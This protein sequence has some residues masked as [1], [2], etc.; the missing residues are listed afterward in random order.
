MIALSPQCSDVTFQSIYV[1]INVLSLLDL[2]SY[3]GINAGDF[4][5][6][7]ERRFWYSNH[8]RIAGFLKLGIQ[9]KF[10]QR[11]LIE[12]YDVLCCWFVQDDTECFLS[13]KWFFCLFAVFLPR[14]FTVAMCH[15]LEIAFL[16]IPMISMVS[17]TVTLVSWYGFI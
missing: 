6:S 7:D 5:Y 9:F 14:N 17:E 3:H 11:S 8:E 4:L 12:R 10:V 2:V 1:V 13:W 16:W 15:F